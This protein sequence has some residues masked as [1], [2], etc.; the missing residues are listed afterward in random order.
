MAKTTMWFG[1]WWPTQHMD[2]QEFAKHCEQCQRTKPLVHRV[3]MPL[4]PIM[5]TR[6]FAKWVIELVGPINNLHNA[7]MLIIS[8]WLETT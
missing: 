8:L 6:A 3:D 7:N 1:L 4:W 5:A 2:A